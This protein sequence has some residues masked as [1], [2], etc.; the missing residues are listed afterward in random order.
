MIEYAII[1]LLAGVSLLLWREN[2]RL[3]RSITVTIIN[4]NE[5]ENLKDALTTIEQAIMTE[6]GRNRILEIVY[7]EGI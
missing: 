5:N 1:S 2:R 6:E 4:R 7:R 3:R